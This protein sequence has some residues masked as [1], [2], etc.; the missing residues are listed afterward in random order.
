MIEDVGVPALAVFT[1]AMAE[2]CAEAPARTINLLWDA[3]FA[4]INAKLE[5]RIER[6]KKSQDQ[7]GQ[8]IHDC[9]KDIPPEA[10]QEEPDISLIG[11]A[12]EAS[13]YYVDKETPRKMFARLIAASLDKRKENSVHH[14]FVEI[15]KQ[16]NPLDAKILSTFENPTHLCH[17]MLRDNDNPEMW[18]IVSD[19]Y[20]SDEFPEYDERASIAI[21][22]LSRLG[23]I[24][25]P[26][27]NMGSICLEGNNEDAINRFRQTRFF[28]ETEDLAASSNS[29]EPKYRITTYQAYLTALAFSFR[30]VCLQ[31]LNLLP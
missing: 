3:T 30:R 2:K 7:Y 19:I 13:K 29:P 1:A 10:I 14:A 23:L 8:D 6:Y 24:D 22:N 26:T 5:E 17:C 12:L 31:P 9:I 16:M 27:R 28:A 4:P 21:G 15:I 11:P 20:L 25:I 18:R